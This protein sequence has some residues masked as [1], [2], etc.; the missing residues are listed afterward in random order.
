MMRFHKLD[1]NLLVAL[2]ALLTYQNVTR[3]AE[4]MC[5]SQSAMSGCL[6]R[7]RVHFDDELVVQV[8]RRMMLTPRASEIAKPL[9][10]LLVRTETLI[11]AK[12]SFDPRNSN[13]SFVVVSSDYAA[14]ML[15]VKSLQRSAQEAPGIKVTLDR[16]TEDSV[17]NFRKGENDLLLIAD[18]FAVEGYDREEIFEDEYVCV[19]CSANKK[20]GHAI[21]IEQYL[22]TPHVI[23]PFGK[24]NTL[25]GL[26]LDSLG[27][28]RT[29]A[30]ATS[31]FIQ[32]PL[33]VIGTD[34]IATVQ[35][36]VAKQYAQYLP[37]RILPL[38]IKFPVIREVL[39]C[40]PH[41]GA[42]PA[43]HWFRKLLKKTAKET[44]LIER[45]AEIA[46]A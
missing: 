28:K 43:V 17:E 9:R 26:Y 13:R 46:A 21:S 38:P 44:V 35:S 15:M 27:Y 1:L 16:L 7:L 6:A 22:A 8:G 5:L 42:D 12:P 32:V 41:L 18:Q 33:F 11:N 24:L 29:I 37:L 45:N 25:D 23:V 20:I 34:R 2:D 3:A 36:R 40:Q 14:Q 30:V 39:Q 4:R 10:E 19:A 31:S